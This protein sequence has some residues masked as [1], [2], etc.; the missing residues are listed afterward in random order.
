MQTKFSQCAKSRILYD[1]A[2]SKHHRSFHLYWSAPHCRYPA[3]DFYNQVSYL[4]AYF[5]MNRQTDIVAAVERLSHFYMHESCGQ[6]T[7]CREGTGWMYR[8]IKD[9]ANGKGKKSDV[10]ITYF[11]ISGGKRIF[12]MSPLH[13]HFELLGVDE[14]KIT[15]CLVFCVRILSVFC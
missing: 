14:G 9:L 11:K 4:L 7:P 3:E 1:K 8:I 2:N 15:F 10:D 13:H 12:K 5:V 6:C